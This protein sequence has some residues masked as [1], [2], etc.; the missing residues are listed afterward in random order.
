MSQI[1][2]NI[3]PGWQRN[4]QC[5]L[6]LATTWDGLKRRCDHYMIIFGLANSTMFGSDGQAKPGFPHF[7]DVNA[8]AASKSSSE[9]ARMNPRILQVWERST[10]QSSCYIEPSSISSSYHNPQPLKRSHLNHDP[11]HY[12]NLCLLS[13][14]GVSSFL[15]PDEA[16]CTS[17]V[18]SHLS[19]G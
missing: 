16:P 12:H 17:A 8:R 1:D 10:Q 7:A 11:S 9:S 5:T 19:I 4:G 3:R 13:S 6:S 14:Y 18:L 15:G 2:F